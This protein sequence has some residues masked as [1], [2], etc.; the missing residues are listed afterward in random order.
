MNKTLTTRFRIALVAAL[1]LLMVTIF[2]K[3]NYKNIIFI[4]HKKHQKSETAEQFFLPVNNRHENTELANNQATQ[5]TTEIKFEQ[6]DTRQNIIHLDRL[7]R[8]ALSE[9]YQYQLYLQCLESTGNECLE[10][11]SAALYQV[12]DLILIP[13]IEEIG[14][15][16][17]IN[18]TSKPDLQR[19]FST[20]LLES[21]DAINRV[22]L[23]QLLNR[24]PELSSL[25]LPDK[26][27]Q[28]LEAK[29]V[30]EAQLLLQ[31]YTYAGSG[32][33]ESLQ[34]VASIAANPDT[35]QRLYSAALLSLANH[36]ASNFLNQTVWTLQHYHDLEWPGWIDAVAPALGHCGF[37]CID[38]TSSLAV[39]TQPEFLVEFL[40]VT[41]YEQRKEYFEA[42]KFQLPAS[43]LEKVQQQIDI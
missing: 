39:L 30:I 40:N 16:L 24:L 13:A 7:T 37:P 34:W 21:D 41:P 32:S 27:L 8:Q 5:E 4:A 22:T 28:D 14:S 25:V 1:V 31:R 12:N 10:E 29:P 17:E 9:N 38:A 2:W 43:T 20:L 23:L 15:V 35:D 42:L 18:A 11:L 19:Y 36:Q 3:F 6:V 33:E 26:L